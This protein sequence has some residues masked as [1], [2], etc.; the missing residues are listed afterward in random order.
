MKKTFLSSL[1]LFT[2][3]T[4]SSSFAGDHRPDAFPAAALEVQSMGQGPLRDQAL[5]N[6]A[7]K[8]AASSPA[9]ALAW[10]AKMNS[11]EL[12]GIVYYQWA[13]A[14]PEAALRS[15]VAS[16]ALGVGKSDVLRNLTALWA[17]ADLP[18]AG[19]WVMSLPSELRGPLV[20]QVACKMAETSPFDAA[21]LVMTQIPS[22]P[23]QDE[24]ILSVI[25]RW[26]QVDLQTASAWAGT[27]SVQSALGERIKQEFAGI[28]TPQK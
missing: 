6:F 24:A 26:A 28:S 4:S 21:K 3:V 15:A 17:A 20:Q 18:A 25:H 13:G 1:A 22:G 27:L 16:Q 9:E 7:Q 14:N 8:W 23:I 19:V 2:I 5:L 12:V 11:P 10:A